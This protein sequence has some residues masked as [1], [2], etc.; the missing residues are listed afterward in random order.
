MSTPCVVQ[1][2]PEEPTVPRAGLFVSENCPSIRALLEGF[3]PL[4]NSDRNIC[5]YAIRI[6]WIAVTTV[7]LLYRGLEVLY[8]SDLAIIEMKTLSEGPA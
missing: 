5:V 4:K 8:T 1:M 2:S 3:F 6:I 7:L